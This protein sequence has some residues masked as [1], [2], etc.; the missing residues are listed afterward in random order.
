MYSAADGQCRVSDG[1]GGRDKCIKNGSVPLCPLCRF[2]WCSS[3]G[4]T[5][6]LTGTMEDVS[7][8]GKGIQ[9]DLLEGKVNPGLSLTFL[10]GGW[11]L[12][13]CVSAL[14][15]YCDIYSKGITYIQ[16]SKEKPH[17]DSIQGT[18]PWKPQLTCTHN[19]KPPLTIRAVRSTYSLFFQHMT[20]PWD[21]NITICRWAGRCVGGENINVL[22]FHLLSQG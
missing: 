3:S 22:A 18:Q 5:V 1:G 11:T 14:P 7:F 6:T 13:P 12:S 21:Q 9:T 2:V 19:Q 10:N 16:A 8:R 4:A 17:T 15:P 20:N